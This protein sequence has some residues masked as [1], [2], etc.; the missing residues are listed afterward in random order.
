MENPPISDLSDAKL[1]K[2]YVMIR[3]TGEISIKDLENRLAQSNST[4]G[5]GLRELKAMGCVESRRVNV[6]ETRNIALYY[7][8]NHNCDYCT[9]Q[10]KYERPDHGSIFLPPVGDF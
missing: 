2:I 8:T 10:I 5:M 1:A 3:T 4:I 7:S 9:P 6:G